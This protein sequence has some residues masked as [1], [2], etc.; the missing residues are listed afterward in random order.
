M[1][2]SDIGK[3]LADI[4]WFRNAIR[5]DREL[6]FTSVCEFPHVELEITD[7][8]DRRYLTFLRMDCLS[9]GLLNSAFLW[10]S[11]VHM[12]QFSVYSSAVWLLFGSNKNLAD[13][14]T[15]CLHTHT[16]ART[17]ARTHLPQSFKVLKFKGEWIDLSKLSLKKEAVDLRM[18][19][20]NL[21]SKLTFSLVCQ[22][23]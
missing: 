1:I 16:H 23:H 11:A 15:L 17:H 5:G 4:G 12:I 9:H 13:M 18:A 7:W 14:I 3:G 6:L 2:Y 22:F 10:P 21:S 20:I 8:T 19:R